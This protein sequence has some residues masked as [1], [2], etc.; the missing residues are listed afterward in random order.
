MQLDRATR[1][2]SLVVIVTSPGE[3][4][5]KYPL[6]DVTAEIIDLKESEQLGPISSLG[7]FRSRRRTVTLGNLSPEF[8]RSAPD[9]NLGSG[10]THRYAIDFFTRSGVFRQRLTLRVADGK[11][12]VASQ[13]LR[14]GVVIRE[15]IPDHFP[16]DEHGQV[17]W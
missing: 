17:Q 4:K 14:G 1:I 11:W 5:A 9:W 3:D 16:R 6:Y 15:S 13:V 12:A 2:L 8:V 7:E 10:D